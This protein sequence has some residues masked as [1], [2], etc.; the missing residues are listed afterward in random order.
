MIF[1]FYSLDECFNK[2]EVINYLNELKEEEKIVYN[3]V[4]YDIL[5][6][7]DISL[8]NKDI[9][10]LANFLEENNVLEYSGYESYLYDDDFDEED[11]NNLD[12]E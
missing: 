9:N 12:D 4:E 3:M 10:N 5:R 1:D 7:K 11:E 6:I 2:E 8:S